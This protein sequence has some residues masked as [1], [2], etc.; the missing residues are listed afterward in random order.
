[1]RL[2]VLPVAA[3]VLSLCSLLGCA[4]SFSITISLPAARNALA[5]KSGCI[6]ARMV[7]AVPLDPLQLTQDKAMQTCAL[8]PYRTKEDN[9]G[10]STATFA[11]G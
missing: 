1:M 4:S 6:A 5:E 9:N 8:R 10:L 7:G 3:G 2:R 11:L